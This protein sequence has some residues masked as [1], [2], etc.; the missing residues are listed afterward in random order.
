[1]PIKFINENFISESV[2]EGDKYVDTKGNIFNVLEVS[3]R[4]VRIVQ[5]GKSRD[6][7]LSIRDLENQYTPYDGL[8]TSDEPLVYNMIFRKS[9]G[10]TEFIKRLR[11]SFNE[12]L[13][14]KHNFQMKPHS[15]VLTFSPSLAKEFFKFLDKFDLASEFTFKSINPIYPDSKNNSEYK[16]WASTNY[17]SSK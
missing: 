5:D 14:K 12:D 11:R 8:G 4:N 2:K 7:I 10:A 6:I 13:I 15:P 17:Y 9:E 3:P 16:K 1:M